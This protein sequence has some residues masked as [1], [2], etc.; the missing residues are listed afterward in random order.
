MPARLAESGGIVLTPDYSRSPAGYL[1]SNQ[2]NEIKQDRRESR[3]AERILRLS[4][5]S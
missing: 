4:S 1:T 2:A 3:I 5:T